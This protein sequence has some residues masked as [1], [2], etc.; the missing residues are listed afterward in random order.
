MASKS[1]KLLLSMCMTGVLLLSGCASFSA[2]LDKM[3]TNTTVEEALDDMKKIESAIKEAKA[4]VKQ[5]DV[6]LYGDKVH[7]D[8]VSFGD[9]VEVK[10]LKTHAKVKRI[11]GVAYKLYWDISAD[12]PFW[13]SD[14]VDDIRNNENRVH[15]I[16]HNNSMEIKN[17]TNVTA[18]E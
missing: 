13:S 8:T 6:S 2:G 11:D 18:L 15:D 17:K 3:Q 7:T 12:Y 10:E 9:I 5:G 1:K 4:M 14:G 16:Q